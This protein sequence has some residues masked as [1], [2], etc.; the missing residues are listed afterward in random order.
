[1]RDAYT[2][3]WER[4]HPQPVSWEEMERLVGPIPIWAVGI[5]GW[6]YDSEG[7]WVLVNS[8]DVIAGKREVDFDNGYV[9]DFDAEGVRFYR[10]PPK[11]EK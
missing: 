2:E 5:D 7:C 8:G 3:K 11:E 4:E 9:I 1:M 6:W 10:H